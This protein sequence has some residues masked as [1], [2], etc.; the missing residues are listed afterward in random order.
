MCDSCPQE[1]SATASAIVLVTTSAAVIQAAT[2][3]VANVDY[4]CIFG[5]DS[6]F[7]AL[8]AVTYV[9]GYL[10]TLKRPSIAYF[11]TTAV[12]WVGNILQYVYGIMA[13]VASFKSGDWVFKSSVCDWA[14]NVT[15]GGFNNESHSMSLPVSPLHEFCLQSSAGFDQICISSRTSTHSF[16]NA[17]QHVAFGR[18]SL[19]Y[20]HGPSGQTI[21]KAC[22]DSWQVSR[23]KAFDVLVILEDKVSMSPLSTARE[24]SLLRVVKAQ[25][26][27]SPAIIKSWHCVRVLRKKTV[28]CD[29]GWA[30][31]AETEVRSSC[32]STWGSRYLRGHRPMHRFQHLCIGFNTHMSVGEMFMG[33]LCKHDVILDMIQTFSVQLLSAAERSRS[34]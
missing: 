25:S 31:T 15:A 30:S 33:F 9:T 10:D 16:L 13:I 34:A 1:A 28:W 12:I 23:P 22:S 2:T 11:I 32:G 21:R 17:G 7:T 20:Q 24:V 14:A 3:E 6:F 18:A 4:S 8:I 27:L 19:T 29:V 5:A 26:K